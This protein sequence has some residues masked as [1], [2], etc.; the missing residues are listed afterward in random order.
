VKKDSRSHR[1]AKIFS[2]AGMVVIALA[3]LGALGGAAY[4]S[5][6]Y[7][8][9]DE[10]A[11]VIA[12]VLVDLTNDDRQDEGL[13]TLTVNP[14]LVAAAQAKAND[15]AE[16]GYFAHNSPD[17][18]TPWYW[19]KNAGYAYA[20]AGENL[21]VDFSDSK[22]VARAWMNSPTHRANVLGQN[23]TEIGIATA[24]GTYKGHTATFVV[25]MFGRPAR[26]APV[27]QAAPVQPTRTVK[28]A[29]PRVLGTEAVQEPEIAE[30]AEPAPVPPEAA[31]TESGEPPLVVTAAEEAPTYAPFWGTLATSPHE[32]L[33]V[34]Y[35]VSA[36]LLLL[37]LVL[38]TG[39]EFRKHHTRHVLA[40]GVLV[41][42]IGSLFV[43]ADRF[44]FPSPVISHAVETPHDG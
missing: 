33:R 38:T 11:A 20:Y 37:A 25:Q 6:N 15:M 18:T 22:D 2:T 19:F 21:A 28:P 27:A 9:S 32:I 41:L 40:A 42:F 23:F 29:S 7:L 17:G 16:K 8:L 24:V 13:G 14:V 3:S 30:A 10:M 26:S 31:V 34:V 1:F 39:R 44:I 4:Y 5:R 36:A 35:A 43:I 12:S